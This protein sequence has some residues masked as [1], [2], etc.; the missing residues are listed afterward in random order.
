LSAKL[1]TSFF[2]TVKGFFQL[3]GPCRR[4]VNL[5]NVQTMEKLVIKK[6]GNAGD[7]SISRHPID[8]NEE[9]IEQ[10][11]KSGDLR[12]YRHVKFGFSCQAGYGAHATYNGN[13]KIGQWK[14]GQ[15]R[16]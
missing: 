4:H 15:Y 10:M 2:I 16:E 9:W 6:D 12:E 8:A 5:E 3:D 14:I 7:V 11:G 1:P 13:R